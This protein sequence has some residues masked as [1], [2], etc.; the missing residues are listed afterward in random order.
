MFFDAND[1][2]AR[3]FNFPSRL[4][5]EFAENLF[6]CARQWLKTLPAV[7]VAQAA[8]NWDFFRNS[9]GDSPVWRRNVVVKY[10]LL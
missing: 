6:V 7:A 8:R 5:V 1:A 10:W 2:N 9:R 3:E 4:F